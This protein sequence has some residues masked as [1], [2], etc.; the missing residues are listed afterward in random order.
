MFVVAR[1]WRLPFLSNDACGLEVLYLCRRKLTA[2][3]KLRELI[4]QELATAFKERR[5]N[6][7]ELFERLKKEG[8]DPS[9]KATK[10]PLPN[11]LKA[12]DGLLPDKFLI[13][14]I[15]TIE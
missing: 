11:L 4:L 8:I 7:A 1:A 14:R 3:R 5:I 15:E 2:E 13:Q 10:A 6:S 12:V 9:V